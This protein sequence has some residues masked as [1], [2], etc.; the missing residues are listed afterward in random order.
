MVFVI[1]LLFTESADEPYKYC[2]QTEETSDLGQQ[3]E[4]MDGLGVNP[5]PLFHDN[6]QIPPS[7][8]L[9]LFDLSS[10]SIRYVKRRPPNRKRKQ[11]PTDAVQLV[12]DFSSH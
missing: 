8:Q 9:E 12:F 7:L 4:G 2:E 3:T 6:R 5:S 11:F 1:F 10:F